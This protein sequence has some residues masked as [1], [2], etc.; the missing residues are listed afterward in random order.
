MRCFWDAKLYIQMV[1]VFF[2][3]YFMLQLCFDRFSLIINVVLLRSAL[4]VIV[5]VSAEPTR[6][7]FDFYT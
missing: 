3:F 2:W 7:G 1:L 6:A 4:E 5:P